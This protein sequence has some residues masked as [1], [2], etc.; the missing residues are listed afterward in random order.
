[1]SIENE[2]Y[3]DIRPHAQFWDCRNDNPL[4]YDHT[5]KIVKI[6]KNFS[7]D[8]SLFCAKNYKYLGDDMWRQELLE[9]SFTTKQVLKRYLKL[10]V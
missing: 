2:L 9:M 5:G 8:F 7:V 4:T 1:M 10:K 6:C 3:E